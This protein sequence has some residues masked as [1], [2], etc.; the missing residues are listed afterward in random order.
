MRAS[1]PKVAVLG[2]MA[3]IIQGQDVVIIETYR[4]GGGAGVVF[5]GCDD[6]RN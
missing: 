1:I 5:V 2:V 6:W 3:A 4:R